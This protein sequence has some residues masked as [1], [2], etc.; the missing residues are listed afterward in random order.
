MEAVQDPLGGLRILQEWRALNVYLRQHVLPHLPKSERHVAGAE[1]RGRLDEIHR[2]IIVAHKRY[3]KRTTLQELD[4]A[5]AMLRNELEVASDPTL[6][7][8]SAKKLE[9]CARHLRAMGAMTGAWMK[10][11]TGEERR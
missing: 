11:A 8:V 2:C 7:W 6:R 10:Q 5:I 1:I 4:V 9:C 3:H